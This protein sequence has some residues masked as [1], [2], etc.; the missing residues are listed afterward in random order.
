MTLDQANKLI[1]ESARQMNARYKKVVFDEWAVI[2]FSNKG[3]CVL[4]YTGPRKEGFHS[5]FRKDLAALRR[6]I[7]S[8]RSGA[9]DFDFARDEVGTGFEGWM[10]LGQGVFLI[11]NNTIDSME[12]ITRDS[13][14]LSAQVPF[15]EMS[16]TF[17]ADPLTLE[18]E[19]AAAP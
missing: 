16:D 5:N 1:H 15:V 10:V 3:P 12:V 14:W 8:K 17:R 18:H 19:P 13:H 11:C 9:G 2:S 7:L 4:S 6:G